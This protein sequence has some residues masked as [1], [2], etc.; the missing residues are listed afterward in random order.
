MTDLTDRTVPNYHTLY[1]PI[2]SVTGSPISVSLSARTVTDPSNSNATPPLPL[3]CCTTSTSS[4]TTCS[5]RFNILVKG[6]NAKNSNPVAICLTRTACCLTTIYAQ[7][8]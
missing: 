8:N 6:T 3:P 7:R 5:V 1:L 4:S 2:L